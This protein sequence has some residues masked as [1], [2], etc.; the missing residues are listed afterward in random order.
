MLGVLVQDPRAAPVVAALKDAL[1]KRRTEIFQ[2]L[3]Q[4]H[5]RDDIEAARRALESV[6][7]AARARGAEYLDNALPRSIRRQVVP[8]LELSLDPRE[9]AKRNNPEGGDDFVPVLRE[10]AKDPDPSLAAAAGATAASATP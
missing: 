2:I 4:V 1:Q 5:T 6:D 8:V 3:M 10:L 7:P 9:T